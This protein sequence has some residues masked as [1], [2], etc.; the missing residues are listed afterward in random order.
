MAHRGSAHPDLWAVMDEYIECFESQTSTEGTNWLHTSRRANALFT[1]FQNGG[2]LNDL[3]RAIA[4]AQ[5]SPFE[6]FYVGIYLEARWESTGSSTD[7]VNSMDNIESEDLCPTLIYEIVNQRYKRIGSMKRLEDYIAELDKAEGRYR[8]CL[9][10]LGSCW[11]DYSVIL[12]T[13]MQHCKRTKQPCSETSQ[14]AEFPQST[15]C[16]IQMLIVRSALHPLSQALF[17]NARSVMS[18]NS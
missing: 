10:I 15:D 2:S 18:R 7:L 16:N 17:T 3:D 11:R 6:T 1:R 9:G 8:S 14:I 5:H 4:L 13:T 12:G